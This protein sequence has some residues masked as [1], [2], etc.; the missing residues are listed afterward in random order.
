MI[1]AADKAVKYGV[2][3]IEGMLLHSLS[4]AAR[5]ELKRGHTSSL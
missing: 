2:P 5:V 1:D 4:T 3:L